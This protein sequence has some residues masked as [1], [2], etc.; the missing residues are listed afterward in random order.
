M[1]SDR[2]YHEISPAEIPPHPDAHQSLTRTL[3]DLGEKTAHVV[4]IALGQVY[5]I[6]WYRY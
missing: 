1:A 3:I 6:G 2:S 4:K 5:H